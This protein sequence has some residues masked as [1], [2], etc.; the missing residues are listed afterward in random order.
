MARRRERRVYVLLG[1]VAVSQSRRRLTVMVVVSQSRRRL[2]V[3][4]KYS[5]SSSPNTL[6]DNSIKG[7]GLFPSR[8]IV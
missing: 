5:P 3:S 8:E 7:E 6:R 4:S 2:I 1:H